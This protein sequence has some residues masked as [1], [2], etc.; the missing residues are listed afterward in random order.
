MGSE[1]GHFRV[2]AFARYRQAVVGKPF[3]TLV[4]G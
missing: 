1:S 4:V 2:A 3:Q